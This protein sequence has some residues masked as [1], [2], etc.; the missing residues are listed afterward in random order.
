MR[1]CNPEATM[2]LPIAS[3]KEQEHEWRELLQKQLAEHWLKLYYPKEETRTNKEV[4]LA[5]IRGWEGKV[6]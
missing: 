4:I 2:K 6:A 1:F 3:T 5:K